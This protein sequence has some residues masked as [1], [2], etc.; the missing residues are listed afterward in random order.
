MVNLIYL[1]E[2]QNVHLHLIERMH[3]YIVH[4]PRKEAKQELWVLCPM[5]GLVKDKRQTYLSSECTVSVA[6]SVSAFGC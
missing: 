6:Q 1:S 5:L 4:A 3:M 2:M